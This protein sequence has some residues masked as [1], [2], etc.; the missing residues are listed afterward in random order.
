MK[1]HPAPQ[2]SLDWLAAR[3]GVLTASEFGELVDTS[4]DMR[5]G[6]MPRTLLARK[7]AERWLG[8]PLP[9]FSTIDMDIGTLLEEEAIPYL[10]LETGLAVE[11]VGLVTTDDGRVGASPD[12][13]IGE[14]GG[15][16]CKCPKVETHVKYLLADKVPNDY[17]QQVHGG[18]F[19]TGRP[20]W[21]F[22]SYARHLPA[23]VLTVEMDEEI[24]AKLGEAIEEFL[25]LLEASFQKLCEINGGP[26]RRF[27]AP[28][29]EA[30]ETYVS[31]MPS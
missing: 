18:M 2:N 15:L 12:G 10:T 17:I 19:V 4:F 31:E 20:W 14:N 6:E 22:M 23:L 3:A 16:E 7:L 1:I 30:R 29:P 11:R 8:G 25:D 28:R 9:G 26:P 24:Q 21:K 13:L 5:K 27:T